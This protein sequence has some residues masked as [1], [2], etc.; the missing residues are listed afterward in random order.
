VG[1]ATE[2][3]LEVEPQDVAELLQSHDTSL[4]D[5]ELLLTEEQRNWFAE[6]E[7]TL[8]VSPGGSL[9]FCPLPQGR[10]AVGSQGLTASAMARPFNTFLS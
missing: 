9:I 2:P 8:G 1:T 6:M 7:S 3:E 4:T 10:A 5:E